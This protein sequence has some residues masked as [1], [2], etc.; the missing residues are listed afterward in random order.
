MITTHTNNDVAISHISGPSY[1]QAM[2]GNVSLLYHMFSFEP[3]FNYPVS[4]S[5][6]Q[7][8]R[9]SLHFVHVSIKITLLDV[10]F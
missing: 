6:L 3:Q 2:Q 10:Y 8:S 4:S 1:F 7:V 9:H 5:W